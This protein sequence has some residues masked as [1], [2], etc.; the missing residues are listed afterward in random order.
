M[1]IY[2]MMSEQKWIEQN[3]H[4]PLKALADEDVTMVTVYRENTDIKEL[5]IEQIF[6]L[7]SFVS[8]L[9]EI[10]WAMLSA[11]VKADTMIKIEIDERR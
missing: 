4:R 11:F 10:L 6:A 9:G 3:L 2:K 7:G 5:W 1:K 8:R